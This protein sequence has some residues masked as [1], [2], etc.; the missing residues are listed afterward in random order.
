MPTNRDLAMLDLAPRT[1]A[2]S[3][4]SK[5]LRATKS[6]RSSSIGRGGRLRAPTTTFPI[7]ARSATLLASQPEDCRSLADLAK[8]PFTT[9][10]DLR[11][12]YPFGMVAVPHDRIARIHASS[13]TT[14]KP[15]VVAYTKE[16]HRHL[17]RSSWRAR[18]G[19]PAGAP[20]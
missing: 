8:F 10:T 5:S 2:N 4:R 12:T 15:T 17:V 13:G 14:G 20:A 3:T 11:D 6:W 19:P 7:P 16:R 18:S 1:G 9:K